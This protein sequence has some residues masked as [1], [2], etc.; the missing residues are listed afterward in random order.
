M[1]EDQDKKRGELADKIVNSYRLAQRSIGLDEMRLAKER[2]R[3]INAMVPEFQKIKGVVD[4][5]D[6]QAGWKIVASS[7]TAFITDEETG[8][9]MNVSDGDTILVKNFKIEMAM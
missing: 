9:S 4:P 3:G 8:K 7:K 1:V 5:E 6:L 2:K